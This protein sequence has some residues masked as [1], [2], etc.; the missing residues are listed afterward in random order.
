MTAETAAWSCFSGGRVNNPSVIMGPFAERVPQTIPKGSEP[1]TRPDHNLAAFNSE[2]SSQHSGRH[3]S[4]DIGVLKRIVIEA[5]AR[6]V[7]VVPTHC[8]NGEPQR[9]RQ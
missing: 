9:I 8:I 6:F 5:W 7:R 2:R 3:A 1:E 4:G